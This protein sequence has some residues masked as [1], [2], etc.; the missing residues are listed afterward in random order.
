MAVKLIVKDDRTLEHLRRIEGKIDS[1]SALLTKQN[2]KILGALNAMALD[3]TALETAVAN[4][5]TVEASAVT[6]IQGLA[7]QIQTLINNSGNTVD[8]VA[9]QALVDKMTAAQTALAA[10][11]SANTPA[12]S[13]SKLNR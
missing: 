4:E 5:T 9:L 11:V 12:A 10:A 2:Q 13:A 3:I 7:E 6:L 8:P 1:I